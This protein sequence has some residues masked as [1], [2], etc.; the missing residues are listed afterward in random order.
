VLYDSRVT[1]PLSVGLYD[2]ERYTTFVT[3]PPS[4]VQAFLRGDWDGES[5][6]QAGRWNVWDDW[7]SGWLSRNQSGQ[8]D[9]DFAG[10]RFAR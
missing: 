4:A 6:W 3:V 2:G 1:E 9:K 8:G 10:I 5:L 7:H